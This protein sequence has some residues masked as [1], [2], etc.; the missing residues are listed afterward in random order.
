MTIDKMTFLE[1]L[2]QAKD[3]DFLPEVAK[4]TLPCSS[5]LFSHSCELES[6]PCELESSPCDLYLG[7]SS[8]Y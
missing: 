7:A 3:K 8:L 4:F 1:V 5:M 6:S 2:N